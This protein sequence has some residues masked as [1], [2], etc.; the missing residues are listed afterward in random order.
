MNVFLILLNQ[1]LTKFFSLNKNIF[2]SSN[3]PGAF[4]AIPGCNHHWPP[5][6]KCKEPLVSS[7]EELKTI[8]DNLHVL[9]TN[10]NCKFDT[11]K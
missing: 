4:H 2:S 8:V 6:K 1:V 11:I 7:A 5:Q 9:K 3:C 10:D